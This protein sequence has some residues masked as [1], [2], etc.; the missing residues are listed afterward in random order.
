VRGSTHRPRPCGWNEQPARRCNPANERREAGPDILHLLPECCLRARSDKTAGGHLRR[1]GPSTWTFTGGDE[2]T[3]TADPLLAKQVLY[4]LSYVPVSTCGN[5]EPR[6]CT[7]PRKRMTSQHLTDGAGASRGHER[8]HGASVG[9]VRTMVASFRR[10]LLRAGSIR[11]RTIQ[12]QPRGV[13]AARRPL[14]APTSGEHQGHRCG[15]GE[16]SPRIDRG[17]SFRTC[18]NGVRAE[19][20]PVYACSM[21]AVA[22]T[23]PV[24]EVTARLSKRVRSA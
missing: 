10:H 17:N 14:R 4:Q 23:C 16:R 22:N 5:V 7:A 20:G 2:R 19:P 12:D 8:F 15:R 3:R 21:A 6:P 24:G 9:D 13:W 11:E 18:W 1:N